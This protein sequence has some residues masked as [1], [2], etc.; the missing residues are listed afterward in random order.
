MKNSYPG[1]LD[2][3]KDAQA[4]LEEFC[5]VND[6]GENTAYA[7]D[8]SLD[9]I[10]T[11]VATYG[12]GEDASKKVLV[13]C[14]IEGGMMVM[15]ISDEA[16]AFNPFTDAPDPN[17]TA[18]LEERGIGGLGIYFVKK[19]MDSAEYERAGGR[20]LLTLKKKLNAELKS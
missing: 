12:Y 13:E 17:I 3:I 10:L 6:V 14:G 5:V 20:N 2:A 16:P 18:S 19:M 1:T 15:K 4:H 11:N 8:L 9:E 7:M